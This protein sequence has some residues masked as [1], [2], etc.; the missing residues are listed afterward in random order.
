MEIMDKLN[1]FK[2]TE[3]ERGRDKDR[4]RQRLK[5]GENDK[6]TKRGIDNIEVP[7]GM[8]LCELVN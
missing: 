6:K 7:A 8:K 4:K 5:D 2:S 3:R 1:G